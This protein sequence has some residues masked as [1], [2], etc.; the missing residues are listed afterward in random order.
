MPFRWSL[1]YVAAFA[2]SALLGFW[3][4]YFSTISTVPFAFHFHATTA[5]LWLALLALQYWLIRTKNNELHKLL[6]RASFI[7]FPL[8][9]VGLT[10]I[11]HATAE[12]FNAHVDPV[13]T[14]IALSVGV[15]T[16]FAIAYFVTM[17]FLAMRHRRNL[18][19]HGGYLL[20]TPL[21]IFEST[22]GRAITEYFPWM[23]FWNSEGAYFFFG[24]I[25]VSNAIVLALALMIYLSDREN[26]RPWLIASGFLA[27]QAIAVYF[28]R[29]I[30]GFVAA[31]SAIG[32]T[33][34][35][36]A[37]L[38]AVSIG[39]LTVWLGW[40]GGAVKLRPASA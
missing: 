8:L 31:F 27:G 18:K 11:T 16:S 3:P 15:I 33:P 12:R 22:F 1:Y 26:G 7:L 20:A 37:L 17:Y 23:V 4:T 14:E 36:L 40:R 30:P 29:E 2:L 13:D 5:L 32:R 39:S 10:L 19:L 24:T 9:I 35:L 6:G 28:A 38:G 25:V 34:L 21:I